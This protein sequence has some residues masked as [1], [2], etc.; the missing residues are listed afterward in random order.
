MANN[1]LKNQVLNATR[2]ATITEVAAKIITPI[3]TM[4]L[5]RLLAPDAFGVIATII[6]IV[7]FAEI[8]S[9][10][11]FQKYL[12]QYEFKNKL[13][14]MKNAN[15]AF[16]TNLSISVLVCGII[17]FF[18]EK[19][20]TL[21]G[22]PGLGNVLV[23]ASLQIPI[24]S[25]SSIQMALYRRDFDFK[26]LFYARIITIFI[27]L[28]VTI[29]LAMIGLDYWSLIIGTLC[30]AISNGIV[31]TLRS[32]WKPTLFY[33]FKILK[34]MFSFSFWSLVEA[35]S[36][37]LTV[38]VDIFIVGSIFS[39]YL[40]GLYR[41][42]TT[43]VTS[44]L[45][46]ITA[47][48]TPIL[49]SAL[50]RLQND[51]EQFSAMFYKM[52]KIISIFLF[53]LGIVIFLFSDLIVI[54]LL[55]ERWLDAS[56]IIG[57]WGLTSSIVI[58]FSHFCSEVYRAKGK[59]RLSFISQLLHLIILI[60]TCVISA[61]IG[62]LFFVISRSLI[63]FQG[64]I[65]H[66]YIMKVFFQFNILKLITNVLPAAFSS[67]TLGIIFYYIKNL[68]NGVFWDVGLLVLYFI[69]YALSL[70]LFPSLRRD[71]IDILKLLQRK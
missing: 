61:K 53:P 2:W 46:L 1:L 16:W 6:M 5:A 45:A 14:K 31:L 36:I 32:E 71:I 64:V 12:I 37:W 10:A 69:I 30:G 68:G 44:L 48:T 50:S 35:I 51:D 57:I 13:E 67:L 9:D 26:T 60:P 20:A 41:T 58:V 47:A 8:F 3:T 24:T 17:Y 27:P 23:V 63:R 25:F 33:S 66:F 42:S 19:I 11:G 65:I 55:G 34:K 62:F 40:L 4:I 56:P 22:N 52:Q 38:W 59:P 54:I 18:A 49:F 15:V 28:F 29:P 43:M 39:E 70:F 7:S 21:V